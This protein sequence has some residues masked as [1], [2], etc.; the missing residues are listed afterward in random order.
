MTAIPVRVLPIEI[1]KFRERAVEVCLVA[2]RIAEIVADARL[3]RSKALGR[4]IFGDGFIQFAL[5]VQDGTKIAMRLP[6]VRTEAKSVAIGDSGTPHI[7]LV[8]V[9]DSP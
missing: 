8:V 2:K 4:A 7:S 6:E 3:V 5:I 1:V 9:R